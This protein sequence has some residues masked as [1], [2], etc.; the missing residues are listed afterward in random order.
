MVATNRLTGH[1]AGFFSVY[2]LPPNQAVTSDRQR[3]INKLRNQT[4]SRRSV[5]EL[6]VRKTQTLLN[7]V[8]G[9]DRLALRRAN[10]D[11][12]FINQAATERPQLESD[13]WI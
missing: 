4:P 13:R 3:R 12:L 2:T 7:D 9:E 5:P 11:A 1:S 8:T 10:S 6:I